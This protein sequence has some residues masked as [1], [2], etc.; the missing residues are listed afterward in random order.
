MICQCGN[1]LRFEN[2]TS[3]LCTSKCNANNN[4]LCGVDKYFNVYTTTG[5]NFKED[6]IIFLFENLNS[7]N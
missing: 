7:L 3:S 5:L 4:Q 2:V 6:L 1:S